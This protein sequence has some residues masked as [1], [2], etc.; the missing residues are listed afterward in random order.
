MFNKGLLLVNVIGIQKNGAYT[1]TCPKAFTANGQYICIV[2]N[3][4]M[5]YH[6]W[7]FS[8]LQSEYVE[9]RFGRLREQ[10]SMSILY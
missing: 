4:L 10:L 2:P 3:Q 8:S 6:I 1:I 7:K 5:V 9:K